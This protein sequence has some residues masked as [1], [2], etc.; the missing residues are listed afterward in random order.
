MRLSQT[1]N[2]ILNS[3]DT[4]VIQQCRQ[5][6]FGSVCKATLTQDKSCKAD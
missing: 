3:K 1:S 6:S 4:E 5:L 2:G